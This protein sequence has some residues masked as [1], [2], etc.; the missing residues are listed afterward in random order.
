MSRSS[1][2]AAWQLPLWAPQM[3]LAIA[4]ALAWLNFFFTTKWASIDGALHGRKAPWYAAALVAATV[5]AIANHRRVGQPVRLGR[6]PSVSILLAGAAVIAV[7]VFSR[8][9]L[10]TWSQI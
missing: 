6:L 2:F 1:P 8:L 10:S 5:L 7:M 9:P 3:A 4:L